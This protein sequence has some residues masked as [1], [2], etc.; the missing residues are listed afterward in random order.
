[1]LTIRSADSACYINAQINLPPTFK[2]VVAALF[3]CIIEIVL[4]HQLVVQS[5]FGQKTPR[6]IPSEEQ[7]QG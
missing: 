5:F 2:F 4:S 7:F 1:M 3:C 6:P